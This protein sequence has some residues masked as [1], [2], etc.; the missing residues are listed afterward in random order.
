MK[1]GVQRP[2]SPLKGSPDNSSGLQIV[3]MKRWSV[4]SAKKATAFL[5]HTAM[6]KTL[7]H[8]AW[9]SITERCIP[10]KWDQL[11]KF[12]NSRGHTLRSWNHTAVWCVHLRSCHATT[13]ELQIHQG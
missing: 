9:N 1:Q 8:H 3:C 4:D 10:L 7:P 12:Q 2:K 11:P 6:T 13:D 5:S